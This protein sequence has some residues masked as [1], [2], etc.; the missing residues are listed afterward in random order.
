MAMDMVILTMAMV[1]LIMVT[2]IP[3]T[4]ITVTI[5]VTD[6]ATTITVMA[7]IIPVTSRHIMDPAGLLNRTGQLQHEMQLLQMHGD[8]VQLAQ[9]A[10][11]PE[12]QHTDEEATAA[13]LA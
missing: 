4:H 2:D 11:Q 13:E 7:I 6:A 10:P 12:H 8:W 3:I 5:M 1:T 9:A